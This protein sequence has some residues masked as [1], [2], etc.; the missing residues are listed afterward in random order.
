[1]SD[2][3]TVKRFGSWRL[4]LVWVALALA[5]LALLWKLFTL[6]LVDRD[7][8]QGQGDARTIRTEPLV[9][10]RGMITDRNGEPLAISTPV[11]SIW[12]NPR[13]IAGDQNVVRQLARSLQ[14]N[15]ES[16]LASVEANAEREFLYVRR[17]MPPAEADAVLAMS[18]P[19][20]YAR[21]EYQRYYPQGEVTAHVL[22]FSNVDDIGQEGLELAFDEWLKGVPGRQQVIKDRRGRII[23][24]LDT[25]QT[26]QPGNTLALSIDFRL[27]NLAYKELKA[28]FVHRDA[29]AASAVV[30]DVK[31]GEVLAMVNQPSFNPHNRASLADFGAL[32]NRS[33]TD[34]FEPGSTLKPFTAI[35]ALESGLY[36]GSTIIST[37]PGRMRVG[38]DVVQDRGRNFGDVTLEGMLV[39]SSN[40]ASAKV[41]LA[42]GHEALRDVLLRVGF[43]ENPA[44]GFPGERAGVMPNHRI[45]H[46]IE[47]A[48]LSFGYGMST[49]TLQLA[50]AYSV[51][52]N[53]GL[54]VPVTLLRDGNQMA[55]AAEPQRVVDAGV[56]A[57]VQN[58]L[59]AVVDPDQGGF[60][61]ASVPF[62]SIAG[63]TGTARVVGA[64][65][66]EANL[67]NSMFAGYV[68]ADDPRIVVIIIVNE[69]KGA[70]HY[71]SQ[72]AAPVFARIASG[73]MR[74][75]EVT[76][77][78]IDP[79]RIMTLSAR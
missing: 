65:G 3:Q 68:P 50:Q 11:K 4:S 44:S 12:V 36:D 57:Q 23:R 69:P 48:T 61:G 10:H 59:E 55:G 35:A 30:L 79:S 41:A 72:V 66:Y 20:V 27:Q 21:Q 54:R 78:A 42:V 53:G 32:R 24:Q 62:Y 73:A 38:R 52:A 43:G 56:I 60:D 13:E 28:E 47:L 39:N 17:R 29:R 14:L 58:M 40:I 51:I 77:D 1:M 22:G 18:L 64:S 25:I 15:E 31:T 2:A 76:P 6:L 8:L 7:F 33:V 9:A 75:L 45:W 19:G 26:A 5:V 37:H 63:K 46:D 67:H 16:L 71:G 70:E 34:L 74:L 49:S